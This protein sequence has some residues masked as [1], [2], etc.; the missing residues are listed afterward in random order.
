M[1]FASILM[2]TGFAAYA[3]PSG[4][5]L[6]N[7]QGRHVKL[8][9]YTDGAKPEFAGKAGINIVDASLKDKN[10]PTIG[11]S[12]ANN[13]II[14][15]AKIEKTAKN[16]FVSS[17]IATKDKNG[18]VVANMYRMSGGIWNAIPMPD[19]SQLGRL[20]YAQAGN[21]DVWF[22]NWSD[23]PAGAAVGAAGKNYTAFYSGSNPTTN[24]PSSGKAVY[25]VKGINAYNQ[26][27]S[28]MMRGQLTAD[29][30]KETLQGT[31]SRSDLSIA[32]NARID[33]A[34]AS[35]AGAQGAVA[36]VA[37]KQLTGEVKGQFFGNQG[38]ALAG[39]ADFGQNNVNNTAFGGAKVK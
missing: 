23:V 20:S 31:I 26:A 37:G 34:S 13:Q 5:T 32:L 15:F 33:K 4:A 18:V 6:A 30:G 35:F 39:V 27:N 2:T 21:E 25:D 12:Y 11:R 22:G 36:T 10:K 14:S 38:A 7:E 29:F 28:Q 8:G 1:L 19:H 17:D 24:L 16:A 3:A 9:I